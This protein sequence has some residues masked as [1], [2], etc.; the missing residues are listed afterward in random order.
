[1]DYIFLMPTNKIV[2]YLFTAFDKQEKLINFIKYYKKNKSGLK[3]TL[4]ICYKLLNI[5]EI[6]KTRKYLKNINYI[7]FIDPIKKNDWDFGSYKRVSKLFYNKEILFLNSHSY[8]ICNNWLNKLFLF[9]KK[10]TV[11][12]PTASYESLVDS[13]KLK[14]KFHKIIRYLI[15]K[16]KFKMNFDEFPNP[17]IRT[18]SFLINSKLFFNFIKFKQLRN[19]EDTLKI[20][21]GKNSLTKYLKKKG[22]ITYVVNSDGK[23]FEEKNWKLSET[24]C[25]L[26]K[27]KSIISDKH[28][29]KY[30]KLSNNEKKIIRSRVWGTEK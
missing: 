15:R 3:H 23:K 29:R 28:S 30:L 17:H 25:Y 4:V 7:E 26:N 13:I 20:E 8:P 18:S 11:I 21:S 2:C 1:M 5:T 6:V 12:A 22:I 14:N 16:Y 10:N 27:N 9:K 19:K 24:Y